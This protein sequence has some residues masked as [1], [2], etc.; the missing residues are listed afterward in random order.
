[1]T[2]KAKRVTAIIILVLSM[3]VI[4][5]FLLSESARVNR[6][7]KKTKKSI[8]KQDIEGS[9]RYV[10]KSYRDPY[11][12]DYKSIKAFFERFFKNSDQSKILIIR[13]KKE[14]SSGEATVTMHV[15][16]NT[17]SD[18]YGSIRGREY[19]R[20]TLRKEKDKTWRCIKGEIL[21]MNP[22]RVPRGAF[23]PKEVL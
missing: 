1:M 18:D 23:G 21:E 19:I 11:G 8:E 7:I 10:S 22:F 9:L 2:I 3:F 20:L 12:H 17:S 5:K 16:I 4:W 14:F 15:I 13:K 6:V